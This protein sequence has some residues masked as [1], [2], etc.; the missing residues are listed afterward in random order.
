ML[1]T[2]F[3]DPDPVALCYPDDLGLDVLGQHLAS[4]RALVLCCLVE[5][6]ERCH[7]SGC[8]GRAP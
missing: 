4:E 5:V 6:D 2:A 7:R 3:T 8:H 1:D